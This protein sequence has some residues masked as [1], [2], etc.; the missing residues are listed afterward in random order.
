M[1]MI[2]KLMGMMISIPLILS[3]CVTMPEEI[4]T[5]PTEMAIEAIVPPWEEALLSFAENQQIAERQVIQISPEEPIKYPPLIY[6]APRPLVCSREYLAQGKLQN[7]PNLQVMWEHYLYERPERVWGEIGGVVEYNGCLPED[8]GGWR[9]A[10]TVRLS[11]MLNKADHKVPYI[12]GQTVSGAN[13]DQYFYRLNDVQDYFSEKFG[14]PDIHIETPGHLFDLPNDPG[15]FL[16]SCHD[17][18]RR[19]NGRWR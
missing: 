14:K 5:R 16:I 3:A 11:H 7:R 4:K 2:N 10:C 19:R 8:K 9:N 1:D 17:M 12:K 13:G 6:G 18:E 15:L